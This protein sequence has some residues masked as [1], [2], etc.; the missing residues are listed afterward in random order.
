VQ[1]YTKRV[2]L[3]VMIMR[4]ASERKDKRANIDRSLLL[5]LCGHVLVERERERE[6]FGRN[7]CK[8]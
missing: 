4:G 5:F 1:G 7:E 6:K 3:V 2:L 8:F